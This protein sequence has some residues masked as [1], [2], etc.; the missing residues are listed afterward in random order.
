MSQRS[1]ESFDLDEN[2]IDAPP[3]G[4][5]KD[6]CDGTGAHGIPEGGWGGAGGQK[7]GAL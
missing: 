2:D 6:S 1:H 5:K 7:I 4:L 3:D